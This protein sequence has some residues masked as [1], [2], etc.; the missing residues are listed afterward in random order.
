MVRQKEINTLEQILILFMVILAV[1]AYHLPRL[2][3]LLVYDR[4]AI[5]GGEFWRLATAPVVHFSASHLFWDVLI[6]GVSGLAINVS[7]FRGLW[8]VCSLGTIIPGLIFLLSYPELERY[9]G[10]SG[11][12][13]GA[14]A[15]YCLCKAR[16]S[17]SHRMIWLVLLAMMGIKIFIEAASGVPLF[18]RVESASFRVLPSAHLAGFL[19][20]ITTMIWSWFKKSQ[21]RQRRNYFIAAPGQMVVGGPDGRHDPIHWNHFQT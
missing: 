6:F 21:T 17:A 12:A 19:G 13:T 9:G 8:L 10:L 11:L 7:G 15:Y 3:D 2:S 14:A 5:L 18:A 20:A 16:E 4:Q 1:I